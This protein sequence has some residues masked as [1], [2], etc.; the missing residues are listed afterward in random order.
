MKKFEFPYIFF[1]FKNVFS[2]LVLA[3]SAAAVVLTVLI[4][5][6]VAVS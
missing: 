5:V 1:F 2:R 4:V 3:V 6:Y